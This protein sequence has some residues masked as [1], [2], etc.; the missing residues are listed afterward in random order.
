MKKF[1]ILYSAPVDA[2]AQ[3]LAATPEEQAK[4]MEA[5]MNWAKKCGDQLVDLGSPLTN[6]RVL[7]PAGKNEAGKSQIVGYSILRAENMD[8][9]VGLMQGHPHIA[10][11]SPDATIEIH[12][13]M[14]LPGM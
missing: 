13:S 8:A 12:E 1:L 4:G 10:G 7:R 3:T 5:W 14:L 6:A 11:W 2:M 9:L